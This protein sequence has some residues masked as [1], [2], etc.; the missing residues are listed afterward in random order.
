MFEMQRH[1]EIMSMLEEQRGVRVSDLSRRFG[2]SRNTIRRDFS[3]LSGQGLI[4]VSR[5]GAILKKDAIESASFFLRSDEHL[6]EKVRIAE[7][8]AELINDGDSIILGAGT[9]VAQIGK[10]IKNKKRDLKVVT[11]ALSIIQELMDAKNITLVLVGGVINEGERSF[12]GFHAVDLIKQFHVNKAFL[13]C[14]GVTSEVVSNNDTY[15][16]EIKRAIR[17][18]SERLILVTIHE[19]IGRLSLVPVMKTKEIDSIITGSGGSTAEIEKIRNAGVEV[20]I[21]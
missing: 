5:G 7:K 17:S 18:I 19:R 20:F 21:A 2:V 11:N 12:V 16:V 8:A 3:K 10:A 9:T 15:E 4:E 13:S 6:E 14:S 1:L